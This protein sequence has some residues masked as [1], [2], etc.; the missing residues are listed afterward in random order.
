MALLH[1]VANVADVCGGPYPEG[2]FLHRLMGLSNAGKSAE[3]LG[4]FLNDDSELEN[5]HQA[6]ATQGQSNMNENTAF[7]FVSYVNLEGSI[8]ELDGRRS[9]P[10][11]KGPCT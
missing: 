10:L 11:Y 7:H 6:H 8:W 9:K 3:E 4:A 5:V 2:S 1:S